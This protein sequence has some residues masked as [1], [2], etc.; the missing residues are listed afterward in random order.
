MS[1]KNKC[2]KCGGWGWIFD[3]CSVYATP[4]SACQDGAKPEMVPVP[5]PKIRP[6]GFLYWTPEDWRPE[7]VPRPVCGTCDQWVIEEEV[8]PKSPVCLLSMLTLAEP[9]TPGTHAPACL[10]HQDFDAWRGSRRGK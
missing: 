9:L 5:A 3:G 1:I 7:P 8:D 10:H 2:Q 4:C 6:D